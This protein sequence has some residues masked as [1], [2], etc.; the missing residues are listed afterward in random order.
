MT[1]K[2]YKKTAKG[3]KLLTAIKQHKLKPRK[4]WF[5][6]LPK[7]T[8]DDLLGVKQEF[9]AGEVAMPVTEILRVIQKETPLTVKYCE[10]RRW[11][12]G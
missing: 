6:L 12:N 9:Q 10:F 5:D 2:C 3:N 8:Q 7:E 1:R 11:L 4:T